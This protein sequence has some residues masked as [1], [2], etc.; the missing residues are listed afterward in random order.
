MR[1]QL[2]LCTGAL[3]FAGVCAQAQSLDTQQAADELVR[4]AAPVQNYACGELLVGLAIAGL[5][6]YG[7]SG[8]GLAPAPDAG[9]IDPGL[10]QVY[11]AGA[12][13]ILAFNEAQTASAEERLQGESIA[14]ALVAGPAQAHITAAVACRKRVEQWL[15]SGEIREEA[16]EQA[17]V[18]ARNT[19]PE[20]S[21]RLPD[22]ASGELTK[23]P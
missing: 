22:T 1:T 9:S 23:Q 18:Q 17:L 15:S 10:A 16:Y 8:K 14:S 20:I 21:S 4:A 6:E 13:S 3:L 19:L 5:R 7:A 12:A 11:D 2:I